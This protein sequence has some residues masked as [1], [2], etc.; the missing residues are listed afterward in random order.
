MLISESP[1][2]CMVPKFVNGPLFCKTKLPSL[3]PIRPWLR[4]P[5]PASVPNRKI[6]PAYMPP[7]CATSRAISGVGPLLTR[8][9]TKGAMFVD[10]DEASMELVP[11]MTL[12]SLAQMP[13]L[14]WTALAK[15]AA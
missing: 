5:K 11:V 6:L 7:N 9:P 15:I 4:T 1:L 13:A 8:E 10:K 2:D 3:E 14:T 12:R